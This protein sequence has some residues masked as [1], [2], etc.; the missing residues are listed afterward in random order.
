MAESITGRGCVHGYCTTILDIDNGRKILEQCVVEHKLHVVFRHR[1]YGQ[2]CTSKDFK[3]SVELFAC[4]NCTSIVFALEQCTYSF[5][6]NTETSIVSDE[7]F[8]LLLKSRAFG[9]HH[10]VQSHAD[11]VQ[12]FFDVS[13]KRIQI[14]R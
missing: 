9:K 8:E 11:R 6:M 7:F 13:S 4:I 1:M 14:F 2:F 12:M 10:F 5:R 3:C